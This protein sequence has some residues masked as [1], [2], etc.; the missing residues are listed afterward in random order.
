[1]EK[2]QYSESFK[3]PLKFSIFS[4]QKIISLANLRVEAWGT[5]RGSYIWYTMYG[6][7]M[8]IGTNILRLLFRNPYNRLVSAYNDHTTRVDTHPIAGHRDPCRK[9]GKP[10]Q[11]PSSFSEFV[12]CIIDTAHDGQKRAPSLGFGGTL[13]HYWRPQTLL[14]NFCA[15]DYNI[16]GH[17]EHMD[18][19]ITEALIKLKA[20]NK[21]PVKE[22]SS[23][24]NITIYLPLSYWYSQLDSAL[25][26]DIQLLYAH[27]FELLGFSK[28]VPTYI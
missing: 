21:T 13:E 17:V 15:S 12:K 6:S 18:A 4:I 11:P 16:I 1:M 20:M 3:K 24:N 19:D 22:N 14:C 2:L 27:D 28:E 5:M 23:D 9:R 7:Y 25:L 8:Y 26:A 10:S